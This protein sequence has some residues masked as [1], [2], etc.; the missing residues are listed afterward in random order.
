M[1]DASTSTEMRHEIGADRKRVEDPRLLRG[2]GQYVEDLPLHK[3]VEVAFLRSAHAHA[4]LTHLD[5]GAARH[6]PGVLEVWTGE[7][8]RNVT[9][10][11]T[12]AYHIDEYGAEG[13]CVYSTNSPTG[14]YR[15]ADR[16][17]AEFVADRTGVG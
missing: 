13:F 8:V 14:P 15:G 16:P 2:E 3:V 9:D 1:I 7:Q 10:Y 4:R 5:V 12:G 17:Q 11:A 6:A